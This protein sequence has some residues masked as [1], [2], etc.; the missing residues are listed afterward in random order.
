M[1][2]EARPHLIGIQSSTDIAYANPET[3]SY[4]GGLLSWLEM[5]GAACIILISSPA[6]TWNDASMLRFTL[7]NSYQV[8]NLNQVC[9]PVHAVLIH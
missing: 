7:G 3:I 8:Q 5:N 4:K 6:L 9:L 2:N 1:L